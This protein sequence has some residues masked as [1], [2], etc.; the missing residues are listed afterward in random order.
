MRTSKLTNFPS[1]TK[2]DRVITNPKEIASEFE[3]FWSLGEAFSSNVIA[4]KQQFDISTLADSNTF[5]QITEAIN[6]FKLD[7]TLATLKGITP[8]RDILS[9]PMVRIAPFSIKKCLCNLY[10]LIIISGRFPNAWKT[11]ILSPNSKL[12]KNLSQIGSYRPISLLSILSKI[13]EKILARRF[14]EYTKQHFS[15][16]QHA[17]LPGRGVHSIGHQRDE[18]LRKYLSMRKQ[19]QQ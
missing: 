13:L 19:K 4:S 7:Q 16:L 9:Y 14:F 11:A 5:L 18:T 3:A 12:G 2:S 1:I 17:F 8:L 15:N 6:V 10:N